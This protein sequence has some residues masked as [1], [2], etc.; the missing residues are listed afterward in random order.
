M[1][2]PLLTYSIEAT[3]EMEDTAQDLTLTCVAAEVTAELE[4]DTAQVLTLT[5]AGL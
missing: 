1:P 4:E 3:S 2:E 5:A